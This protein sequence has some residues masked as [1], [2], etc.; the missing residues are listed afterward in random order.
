[1]VTVTPVH[2]SYL[3]K[4]KTDIT[5]LAKALFSSKCVP[6]YIIDQNKNIKKTWTEFTLRITLFRGK[7][8]FLLSFYREKLLNFRHSY[9]FPKLPFLHKKKHRKFTCYYKYPYAETIT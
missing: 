2:I 6:N 9:D 7:F 4:R 5:A 1:M 3:F 8:E